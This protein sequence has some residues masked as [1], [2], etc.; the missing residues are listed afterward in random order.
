MATTTK[1]QDFLGRWLTNADPGTSNATD[2]LGR[3]VVASD[4]DFVGR[5]LVFDNP[6]DWVTATA[7]DVGD[8]ARLTGGE[9]VECTTAGTSG[10][11]EPTAPAVGGTVTDGTAVWTRL[12]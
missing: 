9:I 4:K 8:Y 11:S 5:A 6:S 12:H 2:H 7:Y 10:A 1:L 3:A